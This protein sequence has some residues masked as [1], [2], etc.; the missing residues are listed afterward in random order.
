MKKKH[1]AALR[2]FF[3]TSQDTVLYKNVQLG[4]AA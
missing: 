2:S 3:Y 4:I 1:S